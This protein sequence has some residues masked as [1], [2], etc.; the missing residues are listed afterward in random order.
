MPP[1]GRPP[2]DRTH[3]RASFVHASRTISNFC[4][5]LIPSNKEPSTDDLSVNR[6]PSASRRR[7]PR[8]RIPPSTLSPSTQ[9]SSCCTATHGKQRPVNNLRPGNA[10][11]LTSVNHSRPALQ[12][13]TPLI[14]LAPLTGIMADLLNT[15]S[16]DAQFAE[17]PDDAVT[18]RTKH[19][20][21]SKAMTRP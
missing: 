11:A 3:S 8:P 1:L 12:S 18:P 15:S 2:R 19:D 13:I 16:H 10:A 9:M 21:F 4:W 14:Y 17:S 5:A 20:R 6:R 7:A